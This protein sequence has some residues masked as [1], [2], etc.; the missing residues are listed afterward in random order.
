[1]NINPKEDFSGKPIPLGHK[2]KDYPAPELKEE[3]RYI[4]QL[5]LF[6]RGA[7]TDDITELAETMQGDEYDYVLSTVKKYYNRW[8]AK[9]D[10][11]KIMYILDFPDG[12]PELYY[13]ALCFLMDENNL[14]AIHD[15]VT[16]ST[17]PQIAATIKE[18]RK[19]ISDTAPQSELN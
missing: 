10:N 19:K 12:D 8:N 4:Y 18:S 9:W 2:P 1:M 13:A 11:M 3:A 5:F 17:Q 6:E 15:E 16:K 14:K 7:D